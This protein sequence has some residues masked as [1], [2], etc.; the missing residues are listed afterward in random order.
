FHLGFRTLRVLPLVAAQL[1]ATS[2]VTFAL[3]LLFYG[4]LNAVSLAFA[5]IFYGLS[6]DAAIYFYTRFR[7]EL[8]LRG[9]LEEAIAASIAGLLVPAVVASGT[10]AAVF[11]V[12]GFS[13]L[14][15]VAQLVYLTALGILL[16]I[17]ATY[18]L[19][20]ALLLWRGAGARHGDR[21][22]AA[23][24]RLAALPRFAEDHRRLVAVGAAALC[25]IAWLAARGEALD[26]N[27]FHLR[28]ARSHA[29]A[30][31]GEIERTFG[32]SDPDGV[33]LAEAEVAPT[34]DA[35]GAAAADETVLRATERVRDALERARAEGLV[36][37]IVSPAPLMPSR[38]T[39]ESRLAA[40]AAL[41][42]ERA[43]AEL[44]R[45][46]DERGFRTEP[47]APALASLRRVPEPV[48]ATADPLPGLEILFDRHVRRDATG[49]GIIT[50]FAPT[51]PQALE[52]IADRLPRDVDAGDGVRI[53]VT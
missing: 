28:P 39:Q 29:A 31:Q 15:G 50:P 16:N 4:V 51:S 11:V 6:I 3:G 30:V 34:R 24:H 9:D 52:Q 32:V 25:A 19:L 46:L 7:E 10:T 38:A 2:I 8:A 22:L 49:V 26:T 18:R 17:P 53:T 41:P 20:P 35:A 21:A 37:D 36:T 43:A 40:W 5:A 33:V 23:T 14:A 27:L 45:R 1:V 48:D 13:A 47:F 12:I 42:R 44:E